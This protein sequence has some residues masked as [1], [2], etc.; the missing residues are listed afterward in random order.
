M[1]TITVEQLARYSFLNSKKLPQVVNDRGRRLR[2]VGIGWCDEG[3]AKPSDTVVIRP[4][5][6]E[7]GKLAWL[8]DQNVRV[9]KLFKN[10]AVSVRRVAV[11]R[12]FRVRVAD[13]SEP[14]RKTLVEIFG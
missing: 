13:L 14:H 3:P 2:W 10:G 5:E 4:W 1:K 7:V 6:P 8:G 12:P 9:V 11:A